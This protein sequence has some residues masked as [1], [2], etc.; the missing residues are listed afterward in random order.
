MNDRVKYDALIATISELQ[1]NGATVQV[2]DTDTGEGYS[3]LTRWAGRRFVGGTDPA[4]VLAAALEKARDKAG[5]HGVVVFLHA[6]SPHNVSDPAPL[7]KALQKDFYGGP[8]LIFVEI[9]P[10]A[11]DALYMDLAGFPMVQTVMGSH[12]NTDY[13][14]LALAQVKNA[15]SIAKSSGSHDPLSPTNLSFLKGLNELTAGIRFGKSQ[16]EAIQGALYHLEYNRIVRQ[17]WYRSNSL[18]GDAAMD[19][20][21]EAGKF[22]AKHRLVTPLSS[23]V[24]LETK[25]Q[26][27]EHGL[28]DGTGEQEVSAVSPEPGTLGL[29]AFGALAGAR[30]WRRRFR[31]TARRL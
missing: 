29:M 13:L 8:P 24:V 15:K 17:A 9:T 7:R 12:T 22:A 2:M 3:K 19:F 4:P 6:A 20:R 28:D 16:D 31:H 11:P 14:L 21:V 1:R 23:A 26:Y 10:S 30:F 18:T 5:N 27:K 25:Q